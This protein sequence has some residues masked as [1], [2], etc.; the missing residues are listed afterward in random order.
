[1]SAWSRLCEMPML[2][3]CNCW[4]SMWNS[5][6]SRKSSS[7][8]SHVLFFIQQ[9]DDG[10]PQ[11]WY[12]LR[13][14]FSSVYSMWKVLSF[15][16]HDMTSLSFNIHTK[17]KQHFWASSWPHFLCISDSL[18]CKI[19]KSIYQHLVLHRYTGMAVN[20]GPEMK[21]YYRYIKMHVIDMAKW[22]SCSSWSHNSCENVTFFATV[23]QNVKMNS[24]WWV[25]NH[26]DFVE[27]IHSL[28]AALQDYR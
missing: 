24:I 2:Q 7:S 25:A 5:E 13:N 14:W 6:Y 18:S 3:G 10:C 28:T 23:A 15:E 16:W 27:W 21:P 8:G 9:L 4:P 17:I 11:I 20:T 19:H 22:Y 12:N 1:M 26:C